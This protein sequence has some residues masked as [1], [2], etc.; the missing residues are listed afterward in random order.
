MRV[1]P[2]TPTSM[3]RPVLYRVV[4]SLGL[5]TGCPD[6]RFPDASV[7]PDGDAQSV[8]EAGDTSSPDGGPLDASPL[9]DGSIATDGGSG[10]DGGGFVRIQSRSLTPVLGEAR[11]EVRA[12]RGRIPMPTSLGTSESLEWKVRGGVGFS[13]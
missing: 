7:S 8:T 5:L 6:P 2:R 12:V 9:E 10:V 11:N 4:L 1:V 13:Q 3:N